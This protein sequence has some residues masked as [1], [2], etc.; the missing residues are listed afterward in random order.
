[1]TKV[2]AQK[3]SVLMA[4]NSIDRFLGLSISSV[5]N[6]TFSDFIFVILCNGPNR[7]EIK[8]YIESEFKDDRIVIILLELEGLAFALNYGLNFVNSIYVARQDADDISLPTRFAK[9]IEFLDANADCAIVGSKVDLIDENGRVLKDKFLY[10]GDNY[11]IKKILVFYNP[12]CHPAL[13]F[14]REVILSEKGYLYGYFSEDH[15]LFLRISV[16]DKYKFFNL[17][18]ILFQYRRHAN[19]LTTNI[20]K[21]I[22]AEISAIHLINIISRGKISSI[23]GI[24]WVIP[25]VVKLKRFIRKFI[26]ISS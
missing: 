6:Q 9:Q 20:N 16:S 14:R 25:Y 3:L 11:S 23:M 18:E 12:L 22:F 7:Y 17:N 21:K 10:V 24:F 13:I 19:Q 2:C 26:R 4:V 5:L 15:D 8:K 1:M